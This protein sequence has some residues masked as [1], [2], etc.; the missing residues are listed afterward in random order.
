[1]INDAVLIR[2]VIEYKDLAAHFRFLLVE[3]RA[4]RF[5]E[6][7]L[8][9]CLHVLRLRGKARRDEFLKSEALKVLCEEFGEVRPLRIIAREQHRFA[10]EH[11]RIIIEVRIDFLLDVRILRVELI[12][13]RALRIR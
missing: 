11:I 7:R 6:R 4:L 12:V 2:V 10:A 13:L 3:L 9:Q 8:I 5:E 1:M